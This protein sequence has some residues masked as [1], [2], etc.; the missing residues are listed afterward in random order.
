MAV[1]KGNGQDHGVISVWL[2]REHHDALQSI[3]KEDERTVSWLVRKL[4]IK[5]LQERQREQAK[6]KQRLSETMDWK[7]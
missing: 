4:V 5:F 3:C 7:K 2:E 1:V 6:G